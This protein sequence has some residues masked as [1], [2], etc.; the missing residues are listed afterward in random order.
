MY[1]TE[2]E[3]KDQLTEQARAAEE[4]QKEKVDTVEG[5]VAR[6]RKQLRQ[7]KQ[8]LENAQAQMDKAPNPKQAALRFFILHFELVAGF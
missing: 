8:K 5:E 1:R 4:R 6:L 2:I 3:K 7:Q